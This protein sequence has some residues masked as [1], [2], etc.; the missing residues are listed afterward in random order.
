MDE[1]DEDRLLAGAGELVKCL[2]FWFCGGELLLVLLLC[3]SSC[4]AKAFL[5]GG[6][7]FILWPVR[8]LISAKVYILSDRV[9]LGSLARF[10]RLTI[11]PPVF[12]GL[13]AQGVFSS[14][15]VYT[16]SDLYDCETLD[17][18]LRSVSCRCGMR[19]RSS[20][21]SSTHLYFV[22]FDRSLINGVRPL[23]ISSNS[24]ICPRHR[25]PGFAQID[26][27][28]PHTHLTLSFSFPRG[29][30]LFRSR[31]A[32]SSNCCVQQVALFV[33]PNFLETSRH[34]FHVLSEISGHRSLSAVNLVPLSPLPI[35][36]AIPRLALPILVLLTDA[37][38]FCHAIIRKYFCRHC[39]FVIV[40]H[41]VEVIR[42]DLY[43]RRC[44]RMSAWH[45]RWH[46]DDIIRR[47]FCFPFTNA[48]Q[49]QRWA[50]SGDQRDSFPLGC[51]RS[52]LTTVALVLPIAHLAWTRFELGCVI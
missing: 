5:R 16:L 17:W 18:L 24:V 13:S 8:A 19:Y 4:P 3:W 15:G 51:V 31:C 30:I 39:R 45:R 35:Y 6:E 1:V 28:S 10:S 43:G 25:F 7:Y 47:V 41:G 22:G 9:G 48:I 23:T 14:T 29:L 38:D 21:R 34:L 49:V 27:L 42:K 46:G 26:F 20:T 50:R 37:L 12:C 11:V 2:A 36:P 44:A 52:G 32:T 33:N 40:C